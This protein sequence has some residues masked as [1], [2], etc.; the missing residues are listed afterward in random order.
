MAESAWMW[1]SSSSAKSGTLLRKIS[2]SKCVTPPMTPRR[3][4]IRPLCCRLP[5]L[6]ARLRTT[7]ARPEGG[8]ASSPDPAGSVGCLLD[9]DEL[10]ATLLQ[11]PPPLE[12]DVEPL[13]H[14]FP[15]LGLA[16]PQAPGRSGKLARKD[17]NLFT[18]TD[19]RFAAR[20]RGAG[21]G[22]DTLM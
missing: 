2:R 21:H 11:G 17:V 5:G 19:Q 15:A 22:D 8:L 10:P 16:C 3:D 12:L 14:P 18:R 20:Q 4:V 9:K 1:R 6:A 7:G 13:G